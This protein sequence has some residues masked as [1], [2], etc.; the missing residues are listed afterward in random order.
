VFEIKI[1]P[2]HMFS[3][4][5]TSH[6]TFI[7]RLG[8]AFVDAIGCQCLQSQPTVE[9]RIVKS[10]LATKKWRAIF[11]DGSHTDFGAAGMKDYTQHHDVARRER[12][13]ARHRKDLDTHDPKRAGYLSWYLLWGDS[14]SLL[15]NLADYQRRFRL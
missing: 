1:F 4:T 10:P 6:L 14:T 8:S 9:M 12:Y 15:A 5:H 7:L 3:I 13:R 11:D 2:F